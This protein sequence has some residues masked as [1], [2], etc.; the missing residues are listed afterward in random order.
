[1]QRP[2]ALE[3]SA[4]RML[5]TRRCDSH[6]RAASGEADLAWRCVPWPLVPR[7]QQ[8]KKAGSSASCL[9]TIHGAGVPSAKCPAHCRD[10]CQH[11][12]YYGRHNYR[13]HFVYFSVCSVRQVRRCVAGMGNGTSARVTSNSR[14]DRLPSTNSR[15]TSHS[16][17]P[18][19]CLSQ[20][21]LHA[22]AIYSPL[23]DPTVI[24][25]GVPVLQVAVLTGPAARGSSFDTGRQFEHL[26][27]AADQRRKKSLVSITDTGSHS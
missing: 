5:R 26:P 12:Y 16:P 9:C 25:W 27:N 11:L 18:D 17:V 23:S 3:S 1:M 2:I 13:V 20:G 14:P 22:S 7:A 6:S 8:G 15:C 10:I 24:G 4:P 19:S 21:L